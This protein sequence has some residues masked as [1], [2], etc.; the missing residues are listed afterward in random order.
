MIERRKTRTVNIGGVKIGSGHPVSIQSM[1]KTDTR[2][3]ASTISQIQELENA[4]CELVRLAIK[5]EEAA[6]A[7]QDIKKEVSIPLIADIHFNYKL[8]LSSIKYGADK[9]RINP[10]NISKVDQIDEIISLASEKSIPIRVGVN[11]GSLPEV[12]EEGDL[13]ENMVGSLLKYL[14]HFQKR[15]FHDI[16]LSLKASDVPSTVKAYR[17]MSEKCDYPLHLGITAAGS[18]QAGI[19][20]SSVGIGALILE[21][22]GDTI[23]VSL[24]GDPVS[25]VETAKRILSSTGLRNFGPEVIACPTCGRCQ[26]DL[27]SLVRELEE[28]IKNKKLSSK[29]PLIIAIMG[30][31]VNGPGEAAEADIGIAFGKNKG[32]IFKKGEIIKTVETKDAIKELLELIEKE[33]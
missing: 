25:E 27:I 18:P 3:V 14:E 2:D 26:V 22:I 19:V 8:A 32:A 24:K 1:T 4:G 29:K 9:I 7:I 12:D 15:N 10:G 30:C 16:I 31:E 5:D 11:S 6:K 33:I 13:A 23:R 28:K 17:K 21:G 20:K